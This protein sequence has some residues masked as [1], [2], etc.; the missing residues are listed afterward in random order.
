[1]HTGFWWENLREGDNLKDPDE[2]GG[3]IL[4]WIFEKWYGR[5]GLGLSGSVCVYGGSWR[6][7]VNADM[8]FRVL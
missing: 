5:N 8:N 4:K 6:V 3:I 1:V 7:V 2:D